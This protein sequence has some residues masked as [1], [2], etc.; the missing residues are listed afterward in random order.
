[1]PRGR[2]RVG[3][4][5][6]GLTIAT[7]INARKRACV[8]DEKE[9]IENE[10]V[11]KAATRRERRR[12]KQQAQLKPSF[13]EDKGMKQ[14]R[15]THKLLSMLVYTVAVLVLSSIVSSWM[16]MFYGFFII[17]HADGSWAIAVSS[18]R[19]ISTWSFVVKQRC[20]LQLVTLLLMR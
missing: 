6:I 19:V 2:K 18:S 9:C 1:M 8:S 13:A 14:K 16:I 15:N 4:A 5:W 7:A 11:R 17:D 20:N 3:S 10:I 12:K